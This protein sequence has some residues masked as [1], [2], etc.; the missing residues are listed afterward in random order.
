M[1]R[2]REIQDSLPAHVTLVA[3]SKYHSVAE[4][5]KAYDAGC[6]DFGE[7]RVQEL[8]IKQASLPQDIRWH[9]IGHLQTNKVRDLLRLRPYLIQSVDSERLLRAI[10]AEAAK[11]GIVQDVLLELHVAREETKSGMS[12]EEF[13]EL[14]HSSTPSLL[15]SYPNLRLCGLMGMATNTDDASEIRR[16]FRALHEQ[17]I[18][19]NEISR[20]S[21]AVDQ[22]PLPNNL[23][24]NLHLSMGMSDDY[25]IALSEGATMVRI[26]S[27]IFPA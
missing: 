25:P 10:D 9:F 11:Q 6:R 3:V 12:I 17:Y 24:T 22:E 5:V 4:I 26:G 27:A 21:Q 8:K 7:S 13:H 23:A 18:W 2:W 14:L 16:C 19:L 20:K 15:N 1:T